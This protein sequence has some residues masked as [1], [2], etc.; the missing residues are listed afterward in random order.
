MSTRTYDSTDERSD[1]YACIVLELENGDVVIY[2]PDNHQAWVQS[3][4]T[5][6][7]SSVA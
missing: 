2:D 7:M 5:I 6:D 3:D 1:E 4:A